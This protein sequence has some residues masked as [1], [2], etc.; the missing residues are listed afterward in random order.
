MVEQ[1]TRE[2]G[3]VFDGERHGVEQRA[4]TLGQDGVEELLFVAVVDIDQALVGLGG[5]SDPIYP[6]AS[7]PMLGEL[8]KGGVQQPSLGGGRVGRHVSQRTP[9]AGR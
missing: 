7:Q 5:L 6:R 1:G 8:L 3:Q 9:K 2:T 4:H